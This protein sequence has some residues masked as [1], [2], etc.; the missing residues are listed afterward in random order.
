MRLIFLNY[1]APF[2]SAAKLQDLGYRPRFFFVF[3]LQ[4]ALCYLSFAV[5]MKL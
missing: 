4:I 3:F 5:F 1:G 2:I